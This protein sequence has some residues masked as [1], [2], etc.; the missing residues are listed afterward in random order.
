[1]KRLNEPNIR[2]R[3]LRPTIKCE[4]CNGDRIDES[5]I[6]SSA[7]PCFVC[8]GDLGVDEAQGSMCDRCTRVYK[9]YQNLVNT[10]TNRCDQIPNHHASGCL[11]P[12]SPVFVGRPTKRNQ[13]NVSNVDL[14]PGTG[15]E[16]KRYANGRG[17]S[18]PDPYH[19]NVFWVITKIRPCHVLIILGILTIIC[20][21]IPALWRSAHRHD[22][23]GGF[24]LGQYILGVGVFVIGSVT[25][26]HSKTCT[27]WQ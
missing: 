8:L 14:E 19:A 1:M 12:R 6:V 17:K 26:I 4:L 25:V 22:I 16:V 24:S 11:F 15:L 2:R 7:R 18:S 9:A 10:S 27:C 3:H 13:R 5:E 23:S 21:L 20:S